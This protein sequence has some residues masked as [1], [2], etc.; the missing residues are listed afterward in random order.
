[1]YEHSMVSKVEKKLEEEG[2][3]LLRK[4]SNINLNRKKSSV[5]LKKP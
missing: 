1:M 3:V 5:F 2:Q 4:K